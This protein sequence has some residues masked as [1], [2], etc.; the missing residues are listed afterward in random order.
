[1]NE[2]QNKA[3]D[4]IALDTSYKPTAVA[5]RQVARDDIVRIQ[6]QLDLWVSVVVAI[7]VSI[8]IKT[9]HNRQ[10]KHDPI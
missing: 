2:V 8:N 6:P 9:Y 10:Q 4:I 5:S 7:R 1:M 3:P